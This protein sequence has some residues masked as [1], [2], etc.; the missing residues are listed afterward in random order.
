MDLSSSHLKYLLTIYELSKTTLDV[1]AAEVARAMK[2]SKPSVTRMLGILMERGLLVRER[3]GKIY[4]TDKGILLARDFGSRVALLKARIPALG[5]PLTEEELLESAYL[6][7]SELPEHVF[8]PQRMC[9][10]I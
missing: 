7:A 8:A 4:L 2:V 5:L 6:L 1:G 10:Q 9:P 3:Y